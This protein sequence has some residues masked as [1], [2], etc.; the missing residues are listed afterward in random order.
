[1]STL[2]KQ[3]ES[4]SVQGNDTERRIATQLIKPDMDISEMSA[5]ALGHLCGVSNA[6]VVR[7]AQNLGYK[8]YSIFK[9]DYMALQKHR[10]C[11]F[12]YSEI[13]SDDSLPMVIKKS[14]YL[15]TENLQHTYDLLDPDT[16]EEVIRLLFKAER[17]VIFSLGSSTIVAT[18]IYQKL[19]QLNKTVI[20]QSDSYLQNNTAHHVSDNDVAIVLSVNGETEEIVNR[21]KIAKKMGCKIVSITR[22][23]QSP[24]SHLSD[25]V[26]PFSYSE[27]HLDIMGS[28]AQISQLAIFDIIFYR[29]M[30]KTSEVDSRID[31]VRKRAIANCGVQ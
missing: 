24:I 26:L 20:F 22:S 8:G 21:T 14:S 9:L 2:S 4:F 5:I 28:V 1:M 12:K 10:N 13:R 19:M 30:S 31:E 25:V 16:I 23:G 7:F 18:L 15:L 6:S 29:L 17:T 27:D 3:L 11:H